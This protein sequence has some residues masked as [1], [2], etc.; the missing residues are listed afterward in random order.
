M[1]F[2][3]IV[4]HFDEGSLR[5]KFQLDEGFAFFWAFLSKGKANLRRFDIASFLNHLF[6]YLA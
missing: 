1:S 2:R 4:K 5:G 6:D 3:K